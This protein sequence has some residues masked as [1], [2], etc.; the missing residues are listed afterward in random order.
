MSIATQ[1]AT[2]ESASE[3]V[4][5]AS[6]PGAAAAAG[7]GLGA[8]NSA[9]DQ[10]TDGAPLGETEVG[11][12]WC[13]K[14]LHPADTTVI[15][16]PMPTYETR[17]LAS[18]GFQQLDL[19][20]L[21]GGPMWDPTKTWNCT[22]HLH[23]DPVLLLSYRIE[24]GL[25]DKRGFLYSKQ[26]GVSTTYAD[27][28][29]AMRTN[30]EKFRMT[31]QSVTVYFDGAS[32][33][34]QGHIIA[35]QTE[36]PR[37]TASA[38][39]D[40]HP[41]NDTAVTMDTAF[42]QDPVPTYEQM[43]QTSRA[44]QGAAS[45]GVYC[46]S[47]MLNIGSWIYT[48]QAYKMIGTAPA[49]APGVG[50]IPFNTYA[51][52]QYEGDEPAANFVNTFP[53]TGTIMTYGQVDSSLTTI[54]ITGIAPT[55]SL[56]LT[57]RWTLDITVRPAT[58][59]APFTRTPPTADFGALRMYSEVSRRMPDGHPSRFNNLGAILG[60]I[61]KIA[62]QLAP[63]ILPKLSG[64]IRERVARSRTAG[65][66]S[67]LELLGGGTAGDYTEL[68][69]LDQK[70]RT[71]TATD[72]EMVRYNQLATTV[73]TPR[74]DPVAMFGGIPGALYS[75]ARSEYGPRRARAARAPR[76][77]AA[78]APRRVKRYVRA[79]R[80]YVRPVRRARRDYEMDYD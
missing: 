55:S 28:Y 37:V 24:Q 46:P 40:T 21:P 6:A 5:S 18:V 57:T 15:S 19:L 2:S 12:A 73:A 71:G 29:Q 48:N 8:M 38:W 23:R 69:A 44:Y 3:P 53:Y 42:Y 41:V 67:A 16:S 79:P 25:T 80:R 59:Y 10:L 54:Y 56:R 49:T 43:L 76:R 51:Q 74:V 11:K 9:I 30:C 34:D 13:L 65:K 7:R 62:M 4:L 50:V 60:V 1:A 47:K 72:D 77:A 64:F 20:T 78:R 14:A 45:E 58:V 26:I 61:G 33:S 39:R 70:R 68:N 32:E 52:T 35:A 31:S 27:A 36:L 75:S 66:V 63:A 22:I 17:S